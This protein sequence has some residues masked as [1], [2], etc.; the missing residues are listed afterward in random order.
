MKPT[1]SVEVIDRNDVHTRVKVYN[2]G[3]LSGT[4]VVNTSDA[5]ELMRRISGLRGLYLLEACE[6]LIDKLYRVADEYN[7]RSCDYDVCEEVRAARRAI[8]KARGES[9]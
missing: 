7:D 8:A 6:G 1:F 9:K 4:L 3:G 5:K 2:R